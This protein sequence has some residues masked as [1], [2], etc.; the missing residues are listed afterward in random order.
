M[1]QDFKTRFLV[2]DDPERSCGVAGQAWCNNADIYLPNLP[3]FS[4][5]DQLKKRAVKKYAE[6]TMVSEDW[7]RRKCPKSRSFYAIKIKGAKGKWGVVVIDSTDPQL[8]AVKI[9]EVFVH[10]Q[11]FLS[12]FAAKV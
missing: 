12:L 4:R 6:L 5:A 11:R 10:T 2:S 3:D 9:E 1:H 8:D 7:V